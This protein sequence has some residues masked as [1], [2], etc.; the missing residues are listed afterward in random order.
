MKEAVAASRSKAKTKLINVKAYAY[1]ERSQ[2]ISI[3]PNMHNIA[4]MKN[5]GTEYRK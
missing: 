2:D 1:D 4:R 3:L 5:D